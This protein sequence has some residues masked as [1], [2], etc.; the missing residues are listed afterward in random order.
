VV[1]P[2]TAAA[3]L[4]T[5]K[6]SKG[7]ASEFSVF[8]STTRD[9]SGNI[10]VVGQVTAVPATVQPTPGGIQDGSSN[11][12]IIGEATAT[13]ATAQ[14]TPSVVQPTVVATARPVSP[15]VQ[16]N[17]ESPNGTAGTLGKGGVRVQISVKPA[18]PVV[19]C[20]VGGVNCATIDR[21]TGLRAK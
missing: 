16:V 19:Q 5:A 12:I 20:Q 17:P 3:A 21:R 6:E 9:R 11:T 15:V 14:P 8:T 1:Q 18:G 10:T 2:E 7:S 13:P 4:G